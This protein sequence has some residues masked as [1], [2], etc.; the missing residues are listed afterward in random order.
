M[1]LPGEPVK[2]VKTWAV[3]DEKGRIVY[4]QLGLTRKAARHQAAF[5]NRVFGSVDRVLRVEVRAVK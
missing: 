4:F 1:S 2:P 5:S 3:V